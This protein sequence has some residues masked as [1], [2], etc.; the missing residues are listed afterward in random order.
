MVSSEPH[1]TVMGKGNAKNQLGSYTKLKHED[2]MVTKTESDKDII[3]KI[4]AM[5]TL[6]LS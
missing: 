5:G 3:F 4:G 6:P 2:H 1:T